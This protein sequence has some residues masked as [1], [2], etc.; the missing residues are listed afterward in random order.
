MTKD[1]GAAARKVLKAA[2]IKARLLR[3]KE[4]LSTKLGRIVLQKKNLAKPHKRG[5][6]LSKAEKEMV[7]YTYESFKSKYLQYPKSKQ[8]NSTSIILVTACM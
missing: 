5:A 2:E 3:K 8:F 4:L 1:C 6:P 7:L